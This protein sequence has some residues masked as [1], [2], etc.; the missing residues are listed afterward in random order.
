MFG[1]KQDKQASAKPATPTS[2]D[3]APAPQTPGASAA[4]PPLFY[5]KP[6][7]LSAQ[8][9]AG[10]RMRP[11]DLSFAADTIVTPLVISEFVEAARSTPIVFAR[12]A[13]HPMAL[14]GL[15][16]GRNLFVS[17]GQWAP[18]AYMPA[19]IRRYPFV[20]IAGREAGKIALGVD[21]ESECFG[22][23]GE[24]LFEC[25]K[26]TPLTQ[27]AL[28]LCAA[29][30]ADA[31]ATRAFSDALRTERL[32]RDRRADIVMPG[33]QPTALDGFQIVDVAAF[34]ALPADKVLEWRKNGWLAL[35]HYHWVSLGAFRDLMRRAT[36]ASQL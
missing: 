11:C 29:F 10:L 27:P 1:K 23:T 15:T 35:V 25:E 22:D 18:D 33:G 34:D 3:A 36:N 6:T 28:Q 30:Q 5:R 13:A 32:L 20:F 2:A 31:L 24:A 9:H 8:A 7:P 17:E 21:I 19:Y 4:P 14:L 12:E 26:P 16:L